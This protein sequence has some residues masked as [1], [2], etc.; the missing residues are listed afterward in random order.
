MDVELNVPEYKST[1]CGL[2]KKEVEAWA[3]VTELSLDKQAIAVALSLPQDERIKE[4]VFGE[5]TLDELNSENGLSILFSFLDKHL[6][7]D[8]LTICVNKFEEFEKLSRGPKESIQEYISNFDWI[9]GNLEKVNIRLPPELVAFKLLSKARIT[10]EERM[11]VLAQVNFMNSGNLYEDTRQALS[12]YGHFKE[13]PLARTWTKTDLRLEPEWRKM[14]KDFDRKQNVQWGNTGL[15]KKKLNPLGT[16]GKVLLCSSCGS[17]RHFVAQCPHSW[18]NMMKR[19]AGEGEL[20]SGN[21]I[22]RNNIMERLDT[23]E[24]AADM[25][26]LKHEIQDLKAQIVELK[27][28]NLQRKERESKG[29]LL[30]CNVENKQENQTLVTIQELQQSLS[31][32]KHEMKLLDDAENNLM[33]PSIKE[34]KEKIALHKEVKD[35][36][37]QAVEHEEERMKAICLKFKCLN[38]MPLLQ[39]FSD[40]RKPKWLGKTRENESQGS[41]VEQNISDLKIVDGML[42]DLLSQQL[43]N[44]Y[45]QLFWYAGYYHRK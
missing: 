21:S 33:T 11:I 15:V 10:N 36:N 26:A 16:N 1:C 23:A 9:I 3:T 24:V 38:K 32:V 34:L 37:Q 12:R 28:D 27:E 39:G 5:L 17:Y 6:L 13:G 30:T 40:T 45:R 8:E 43:I 35:Q 42:N 18:E 29:N 2:W 44:S 41:V 20:N 7:P 4:K 19:K 14:S 25:K 31:R 22:H